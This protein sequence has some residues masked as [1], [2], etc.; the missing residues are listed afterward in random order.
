MCIHFSYIFIILCFL[1]GAGGAGGGGAGG[2][3]DDGGKIKENSL[4]S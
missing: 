1:G 2:G 3:G 4:W